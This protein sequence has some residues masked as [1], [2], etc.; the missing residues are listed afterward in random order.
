MSKPWAK[1]ELGYL[2]HPKFLALTANAICLW[3]EGKQYCDM[4]HTDGMIP[5]EALKTFRFRGVKSMEMLMKPCAT[6][7]PDGSAYAPLWEEHAVGF[8]M[9][10]Y[11]DYND[12]RDEVLARFA[13]AA[14][15]KELRKIGNRERQAELRAKRKA[16][17]AEASG[18][19]HSSG[20]TRDV[21]RDRVPPTATATESA[22][23]TATQIPKEQVSGGDAAPPHPPPPRPMAPLHDRSHFK[24]AVCGRVCLHASLYGEFVRRRNHPDADAEVRKW[25]DETIDAWTSGEHAGDEP[26]DPFEFW[27]LQYAARWPATLQATGT[28]RRTPQWAQ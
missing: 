15:V 1:T 25:A 6:P 17:I 24:H 19:C 12:C 11:L 9:H 23:A 3:H 28:D 8:K 22:T 4:H 2:N 21:T 14:D 27:K 7:K 5:R 13:D 26:G 20:V 18:H 16:R 10:D